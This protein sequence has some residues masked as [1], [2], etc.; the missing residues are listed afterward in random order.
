[1]GTSNRFAALRVLLDRPL[2]FS[3][4]ERTGIPAHFSLLAAAP[5]AHPSLLSHTPA[6]KIAAVQA[7][8]RT[9]AARSSFDQELDKLPARILKEVDKVKI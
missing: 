8:I 4:L 5:C 6:Q 3:L 7:H 9:A 2:F 1:M